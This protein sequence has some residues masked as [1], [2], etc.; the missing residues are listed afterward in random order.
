MKN[1]IKIIDGN[2]RL[3]NNEGQIIRSYYSGQDAEKAYFFNEETE[4]VQ[5]HLFDGKILII[6]KFGLV[7]KTIE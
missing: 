4:I 5:V 3:F 6:N 2:V 7:L 1:M